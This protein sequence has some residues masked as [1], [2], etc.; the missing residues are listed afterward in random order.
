MP[1]TSQLRKRR[2][3]ERA[4]CVLNHNQDCE[5]RALLPGMTSAVKSRTLAVTTQVVAVATGVVCVACSLRRGVVCVR[6]RQRSIF[7]TV[8]VCN[9]VHRRSY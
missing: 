9:L 6:R 7:T 3:N 2:D 1:M 8:D 5:S 4:T